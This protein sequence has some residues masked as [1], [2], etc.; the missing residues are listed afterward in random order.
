MYTPR[1]LFVVL[2]ALAALGLLACDTSSP[3]GLAD[4]SADIAVAES[5]FRQE[6]TCGGIAG[7][8]CPMG[9]FCE[10]GTGQCAGDFQGVC[11]A[12]PVTCTKELAPVCG[13]DDMN[14]DNDCMRQKAGVSLGQTGRC[15]EL[16][17]S[18]SAP[19]SG[20]PRT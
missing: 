8:K 19:V 11:K 10:T 2:T 18:C 5:D 9:M 14:Y 20:N 6:T 17:T 16:D 3:P 12:M 1:L 4:G 15:P 7:K 13:C